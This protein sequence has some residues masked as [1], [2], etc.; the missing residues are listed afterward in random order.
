MHTTAFEAEQLAKDV[1]DGLG[2]ADHVTVILCPPFPY[3]ALVGELL[4]GSQVALGAQN[5]YPEAEGAFTGVVIPYC[6]ISAAST[7]Y[8]AT[9]SGGISWE[10]RMTLPNRK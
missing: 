3:L 5:M 9:A 10:S 8:W 4:K 1:I 6:S 2:I 7:S